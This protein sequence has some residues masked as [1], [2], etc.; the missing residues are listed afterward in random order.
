M[1][2]ELSSSKT[3]IDDCKTDHDECQSKLDQ[4]IEAD[5]ERLDL[6]IHSGGIP[7][8]GPTRG[9]RCLSDRDDQTGKYTMQYS[10]ESYHAIEQQ[11]QNSQG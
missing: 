9:D 10:T 6:I 8:Y 7:Q 2:S 5:D 11:C 3:Q 4:K 1:E